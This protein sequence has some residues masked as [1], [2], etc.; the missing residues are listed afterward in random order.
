MSKTV[1][2]G[3]GTGLST[4]A[5]VLKHYD[6]SLTLVVAVTDDGGSSGFLREAMSMPPPGD[7]RNNVI[8]LADDEE[9]LTKVF[10]YRFEARAMNGH[11]LGNIIIAGL[12]EMF[13]SFPEA[14][15]AASRMLKIKGRVLPVADDLVHLVAEIDDGSFIKGESRISAAGK[16]I[17][18][19]FLDKAVKALPEVLGAIESAKTVIVGPGSLFTSV[20]PNFLVSGVREAFGKSKANKVYI[21]NIMTQPGESTGFSLADHVNVVEDYSGVTFDMIFWTEVGEVEPAVLNRYY[22]RGSMPVRNDMLTDTR[23]RV[24]SGGTAELIDDGRNRLV[25]RHSRDSILSILKELNLLG[26]EMM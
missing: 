25:V 21:C 22:E 2:I 15:L 6:S 4:F 11:S 19:V 14:V 18:R 10:S 13:Q 23:V 16:R 1:L 5:R 12:T 7:V 26:E 3:G 24:V 9:F 17:E 20:V 8:A